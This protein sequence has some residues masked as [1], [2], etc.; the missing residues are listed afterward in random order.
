M[1][2]LSYNP[3][4]SMLS[5]FLSSFP[6]DNLF[7]FIKGASPYIIY[8]IETIPFVILPFEFEKEK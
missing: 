6:A 7:R 3:I 4:V 1:I 2:L 8:R 5:L